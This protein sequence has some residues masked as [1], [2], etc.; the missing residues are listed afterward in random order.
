M[1]TGMQTDTVRKFWGGL[2]FMTYVK[3][4]GS[5]CSSI[6]RAMF[7]LRLMENLVCMVKHTTSII[8]KAPFFLPWYRHFVDSF[9]NWFWILEPN[10][11]P[12]IERCICMCMC[13]CILP[14]GIWAAEHAIFSHEGCKHSLVTIFRNNVIHLFDCCSYCCCIGRSQK[15]Y[16][17]NHVYRYCYYYVYYL[18]H[19]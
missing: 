13:M 7:W 6:L 5:Y 12:I 16:T 14:H 4:F 3:V 11:L 17:R 10:V 9:A 19:S 2:L 18:Y 1:S 15:V 8:P